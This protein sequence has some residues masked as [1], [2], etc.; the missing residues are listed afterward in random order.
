MDEHEYPKTD[1]HTHPIT[2]V[3]GALDKTGDEMQG[4]LGMNQNQIRL[5]AFGDDEQSIGYDATDDGTHFR[6]WVAMAWFLLGSE[7]M[8]L[9]GTK[10]T[11]PTIKLTGG[12]PGSGKV[13][14]SDADGDATWETPS[15]GGDAS[16]NTSTSVDSEV[17]IFSGTGGKTLKRAA[18]T[19]LAKLTSGVLSAAVAGT[20]YLAP[21]ALDT[22][23]SLAANS[24]TKIATQKAVKTYVDGI[25][26]GIKAKTA[27]RVATTANGT[28]ASAFANGQTVD[29]VTLATGDRILLKDQSTGSQ[30]GIYTVNASGAPTRATDADANAEIGGMF[31]F[32]QE[33]TANADTGWLCTNDG[34][35]T[36]GTTALTF[37]QFSAAGQVTAGTGLTKTGLSIAISDAE[38]LAIAGLTSAADRLPYFT[39]SG[40]AALATF[41]SF[42]RTL[43]DDADAATARATL[44]FKAAATTAGPG[45]TP[46]INTDTNNSVDFTAVAA[47]IT[48][49]TTNLSGTPARGDTLWISFTDDGTA[50][51]ITWGAKFEA[52]TVALPTTTVISTRL[53]VG[54][55]WNVVTSKWRCVAVA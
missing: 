33:G 38:L 46:T 40:T 37:V 51:A 44:G 53:D 19:G 39:G 27:V 48:S 43:M 28:L 7:V 18:M 12:S 50:R 5:A 16:T 10:L 47:A 20:D 42:I 4:L 55:V 31:A 30:N 45:A 2:D 34:S 52:S 36:V 23:T 1:A 8:R 41:T 22:D 6:A 13:L 26:Q 35:I 21:S 3:D 15:S 17:A 24:D 29:G 25:A 14:T 54:F 9:E 49:M 11:V 32:V